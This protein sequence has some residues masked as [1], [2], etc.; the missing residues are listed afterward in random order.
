MKILIRNYNKAV[1]LRKCCSLSLCNLDNFIKSN[2]QCLYIPA[3][4]VC[5]FL[6][7]IIITVVILH[8]IIKEE[9][10]IKGFPL[11]L[12][13][14]INGVSIILELGAVQPYGSRTK[15]KSFN[16]IHYLK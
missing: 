16:K 11:H 4:G 9:V 3:K 6:P 7:R 15:R 14:P 8:F 1:K 12:N 2:S 13:H 5:Q 10:N